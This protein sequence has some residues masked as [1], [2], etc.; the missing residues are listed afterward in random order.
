MVAQASIRQCLL[1]RAGHGAVFGGYP[2]DA[3]PLT[4]KSQR[5]E[6]EIAM[7]PVTR[8]PEIF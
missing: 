3:A 6:P 1:R 8:A 2:I 7:D 4:R 5:N